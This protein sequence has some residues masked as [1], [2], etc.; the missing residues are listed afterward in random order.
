MDNLFI[1][2]KVTENMELS[3]EAFTVWCGLRNL[4]QKDVTEYFVTY[5]MIAYSIFKRVPGRY[6]LEAIKRGFMELTENNYVKILD[7]FNK[8]EHVVDLSF[9][10]YKGNEF[11]ADL[12]SEEMHKIMNISGNHNKYKLL[13]YFTCQ[14]GTFNRSEDLGEYKGKIGGMS[15]EYFESLISITKPPVISFNSILEENKIL[16][17]I[18]HK[19][20]YQGYTYNGNSEIR[21]IP[22]T[23]S[24]W[25]DKE[26]A[27]K[28]A[29]KTH[30]YKY[31]ESQKDIRTKK[32]NKNRSLGQKLHYFI[33]FGVMYDD[34]VVQELKEYAEQ[35]NKNM[36]K[37]YESDIA[38]GYSPNKPIYIDMNIFNIAG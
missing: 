20:F 7:S 29:E 34:E 5:N 19:D 21:E 38:R 1:I 18:R 4:M 35:K 27:Q 30:G 28:F 6:E 23:Y 11:F 37:E 17:V 24:R 13:R 10:Y 9:L 36:K 8:N 16:F 14:I 2:K 22:N 25:E 12:S 3:D 15:L 32:A 31:Y 26:L 33:D